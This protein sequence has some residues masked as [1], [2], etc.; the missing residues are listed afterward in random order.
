M[1]TPRRWPWVAPG[2]VLGCLLLLLNALAPGRASPRLLDFPASVC[3]QEVREAGQSEDAWAVGGGGE[4]GGGWRRG[5][6]GAGVGRAVGSA[7]AV[8]GAESRLLCE[9]SGGPREAESPP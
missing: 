9:G 5:V 6:R 7:K 8:K 1:A 4:D 2:P 3:A